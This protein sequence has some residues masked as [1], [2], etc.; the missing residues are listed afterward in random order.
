MNAASSVLSNVTKVAAHP[1]YPVEIDVVGY[2]A[3]DWSVPALLGF[4]AAGWGVILV[5][6]ELLV[7]RHNPN[8]PGWEKAAIQWFV[9]CKSQSLLLLRSVKL[10]HSLAGTIHLFF[11]G[12]Y[13]AYIT[14]QGT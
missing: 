12:R 3:N 9:L 10:I 13:N 11:E 1:F 5:I 4:F 2:L 6:T 7:R 14:V 8:L